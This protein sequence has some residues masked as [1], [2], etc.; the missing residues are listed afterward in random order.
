MASRS[1]SAHPGRAARVAIASARS[2]SVKSAVAAQNELG[3]RGIIVGRQCPQY[4]A[5]QCR[6]VDETLQVRHEAGHAP[7]HEGR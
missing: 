7:L 4:R 5:T 6:V 1:A 3:C 2:D